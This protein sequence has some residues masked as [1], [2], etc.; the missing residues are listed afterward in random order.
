[1]NSQIEK[2]HCRRINHDTMV[3]LESLQI[4]VNDNT[5]MV[6]CSDDGLYFESDQLLQPGAEVFIRIENFQH[7]QTEIYKCHHVKIIWGKRLKF[8]P[9]AYGYGAKYVHLSNKQN[10]VETDSDQIKELRK[11]PRKNYD[12]PASFGIENKFYDGFISDISRNGCFI[13]T[14]ESL[15]SGQI[16]EVVIPGT[17]L[18]GNNILKVKVVRLSPIGVGVRF[19]SIIKKKSKE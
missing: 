10:S 7:N 13:E 9:Y 5:R 19:Q 3:T 14:R 15:N 1:M 2:R 6:N 17:R 16:L 8:T 4:G 11:Y 12:K 18:D